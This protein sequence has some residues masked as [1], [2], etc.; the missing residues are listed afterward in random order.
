MKNTTIKYLLAIEADMDSVKKILIDI[1]GRA[2]TYSKRTIFNRSKK[3]DFINNLLVKKRLRIVFNKLEN[4]Q[5]VLL[6]ECF[7]KLA[8]LVT[9]LLARINLIIDDLYDLTELSF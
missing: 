3:R 5:N 9:F 4:L 7:R 8:P 1:P 6:A 2:F